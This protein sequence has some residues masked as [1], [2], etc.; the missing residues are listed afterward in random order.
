MKPL[1]LLVSPRNMREV[2]DEARPYGNAVLVEVSAVQR[3]FDAVSKAIMSEIKTLL[4]SEDITGIQAALEK[5]KDCPGEVKPH[6]TALSAH[7]ERMAENAQ[8]RL[9]S[10]CSASD[11]HQISTE[12]HRAR[13]FGDE[14][15][16]ARTAVK[17]RETARELISVPSEAC[18]WVI[19][20][21]IHGSA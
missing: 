11:P 14:L 18:S 4:N 6:W 15:S 10:L 20:V 19:C 1:N 8:T 9:L 13:A 3:K 21:P 17:E 5:Y 12:L 2:L 16:A 7:M